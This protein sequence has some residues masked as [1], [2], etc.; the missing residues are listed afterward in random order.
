VPKLGIEWY[1]KA[2]NDGMILN[3]PTIFGAAGGRFLAG[4]EAGPEA[5]VGVESLRQ[6]IAEA[7]A[8]ASGGGGDIVIPVYVGGR[9][10]ETVVVD[11][12]SR[13]NYRSGG[14]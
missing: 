13:T 3:S 14:R 2:M 11:A 1:R 8:G 6:M 7:V 4:G 12:A 9:R 5:V 10:L